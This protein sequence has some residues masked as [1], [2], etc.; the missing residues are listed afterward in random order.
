[1]DKRIF[2]LAVE[3]L[4]ERK[5]QVEAEIELIRAELGGRISHVTIAVPGTARR[6]R[7]TAA[8][9]KAQSERMKAYWAARKGRAAKTGRARKLTAAK[10][11]RRPRSAAARKAQS[12]K[13]KAYWAKRRREKQG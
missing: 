7:R 6:R 13:M 1:M 4:R 11:K 12:E 9:R 3:A 8:Q 5:A 2:E 10:P